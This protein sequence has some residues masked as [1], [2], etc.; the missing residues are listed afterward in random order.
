VAGETLDEMQ[1]IEQKLQ[2][3]GLHSLG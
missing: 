2:D 1:H 3:K